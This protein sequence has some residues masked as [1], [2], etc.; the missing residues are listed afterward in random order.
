MAKSLLLRS[1]LWLPLVLAA[2][3]RLL[4]LGSNPAG[5]FRDEAEKAYSAWSIA[6]TGAVLDF[7]PEAAELA[8]V[9]AMG[10]FSSHGG[11]DLMQENRGFG[12]PGYP[13]FARSFPIFVN[14]WGSTTSMLY[15]YLAVPFVALGGLNAWTTRLPAAIAG[16]LGVW[17]A[18]LLAR[19][20]T[21]REEVAF[22]A[23]LILAFSPW[24][25]V[26]SRWAL[27]GIFVPLLLPLGLAAFL[28]SLETNEEKKQ[29]QWMH[30]AIVLWGLAF[31]AYAGARP[32][33]LLFWLGVAF[34][35]RDAIRQ[36]WKRN[37]RLGVLMLLVL[38]PTFYAMLSG[39]MGRLDRL[40]VF[41]G[42]GAFLLKCGRFCLNYIRHFGPDFWF[43]WGD[44]LP[45]H[46]LPGFG[47]LLHVEIIF[48]A[49][50]L[51][52]AIRR[53]SRADKLLL[54][55]LALFPVS[56]ALTNEGIPHALR[57]LHAVPAPQ[58]LAAI[59]IVYLSDKAR[60]TGRRWAD[61]LKA[62]WTV[63]AAVLVIALFL[64]YPVYSAASFEYGIREGFRLA[65][66]EGKLYVLNSP[67]LPYAW[68]LYFYHA[69]TPPEVLRR[70]GFGA[71]RVRLLAR[72]TPPGMI[73]DRMRPGDILL[74]S[75]VDYAQRFGAALPEGSRW[76][77]L[78][79]LKPRMFFQISPAEALRVIKAR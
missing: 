48:F 17:A 66:P 71:S 51:L 16:L 19:R 57:T 29:T 79:V 35:W 28:K 10:R 56:A 7:T 6:H 23:A 49:A 58:M 33:L 37:L 46:S 61:I 43:W 36:R 54:L 27:Q 47:M 5:V 59:G 39:G 50:G 67:G 76:E 22:W 32:F 34:L 21:G 45:R 77:S 68:E 26:F 25:L 12:L 53:R 44:S 8:A 75:S 4:F 1:S 52:Q 3:M 20:L 60:A 15:Q 40:S 41:S 11:Q 38:A 78:P 64:F 63:N 65:E 18:W 70:R 13:P 55:W 72:Q 42:E 31:Y 14:V 2:L 74:L 30:G 69:K 62:A 24:H 9:A 73:Y